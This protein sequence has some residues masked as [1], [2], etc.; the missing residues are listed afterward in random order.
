ML[1]VDLDPVLI[2]VVEA[3]VPAVPVVLLNLV[4]DI[5]MVALV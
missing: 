2:L 5:M 1:V 3:A 4:L